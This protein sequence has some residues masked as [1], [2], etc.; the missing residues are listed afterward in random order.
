MK[1][2]ELNELIDKDIDEDAYRSEVNGDEAVGG[3][4]AV[5]SQNDTEELAQAVGI[6]I[7][8]GSPL[9]IEETIERRDR[10][11]WE[12]DPDSAAAE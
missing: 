11:R 4:T 8:E 12:L 7:E 10:D 9:A 3:S 2:P 5:P 1:D 6:E